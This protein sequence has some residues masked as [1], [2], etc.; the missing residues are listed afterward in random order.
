ME[1]DPLDLMAIERMVK[2]EGLQYNIVH[3]DSVETAKQLLEHNDFGYNYDIIIADYLLKDG[4]AF[5]IFNLKY[6]AP[7]IVITGAGDEEIAIKAMK[8]GAYDYLIKDSNRQYLKI[9]PHTISNVV[10]QFEKNHRIKLLESSVRNANDI[11]IIISNSNE[12]PL[13]SDVLYANETFEEQ[14]GFSLALLQK[15]KLSVL[16]SDESNLKEISYINNE[17]KQFKTVRSELYLQKKNLSLFWADIVIKPI[18]DSANN[19]T[20]FLFIARDITEKKE[21]EKAL[22]EARQNAEDAKKA[23]EHFLAVM[24]HEIRTPISAIVGLVDLLSDTE[25]SNQQNDYVSSIKY[26]ANNLLGLVNDILDLS[27]IQQGN[28]NLIKEKFDLKE[29][30]QNI[31]QTVRFVAKEKGLD[32]WVIHDADLPNLLEGDRNQ[33]NQILT[34]LI[35][36]AIKFTEK[37]EVK[38]QTKV[39]ERTEE[40]TLLNIK[41]IDS[42]VGIPREKLDTIFEKY[43]RV[44]NNESLIRTGGTGLGLFIVYELVKIIGGKIEVESKIMQGTTF[45]LTIRFNNVKKDLKSSSYASENGLKG[46]K[47]LIGEDN[48]MNRKI[49]DKIMSKWN[50]ETTFLTNGKEIIEE[51][52]QNKDYDLLLIDYRMPLMNG[53]ETIIYIRKQLKLELNIILMT[54]SVIRKQYDGMKAY[55]SGFLNKPFSSSQLHQLI[56][57]NLPDIR[58]KRLNKLPTGKNFDLSFLEKA[59]NNNVD[60]I[61]EMIEIFINQVD[62]FLT[63][64]PYLTKENNYDE[65]AL[66]VHTLKSSARYIGNLKLFSNCESIEKIIETE[67]NYEEKVGHL[68]GE[69]VQESSL[70]K[71]NLLEALEQLPLS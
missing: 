15:Q 16:L 22:I 59:S 70:T 49:L 48:V 17:L 64:L 69:F 62:D 12:N 44:E 20:H 55:I 27:K 1:D 67:E 36:N 6:P 2:K 45:S 60:F 63:K 26:S 14:T 9:L 10:Q 32:L 71:R 52:K 23:E 58:T 38:I 7:I 11:F 56:V 41:V 24:S 21:N 25:L 61:K 50:V 43:S 33:I 51:L 4:N 34:N 54:A 5:D 65:I 46:L 47:I 57:E 18:V 42:G 8:R 29:L 3:A 40:N 28:L 53:E 39:L 66:R 30:I 19:C 68:L 35:S 13:R 31:T 37:G